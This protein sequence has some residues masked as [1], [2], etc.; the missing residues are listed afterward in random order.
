MVQCGEI[1]EIKIS[2]VE[3]ETVATVEFM[4][5]V[6]HIPILSII[7]ANRSFLKES[8]PAALTKDKKRIEGHEVAVHLAWESTLYVTNFPEKSDDG[9]IRELFGKVCHILVSNWSKFADVLRS[10]AIYS[11]CA[12][13]VRNSRAPDG[14]VMYNIFL[15]QVLGT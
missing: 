6:C 10:M 1:R 13:P 5:R 14:F 3:G 12:G 7:Y 2:T 11:T 8:V 15:R 9:S 4:E